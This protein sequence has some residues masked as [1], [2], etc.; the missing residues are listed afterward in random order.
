MVQLKYI[1][2]VYAM[3]SIGFLGFIVWSHHMYVTGLDV[4]KFVS[5][6]IV[7][8]LSSIVPYAGKLTCLGPLNNHDIYLTSYLTKRS[9]SICE[10]KAIFKGTILNNR[11]S[12]GNPLCST[13]D[14]L[15]PALI[16]DHLGPH[17]IP[18]DDNDFGH[19]LAGL[20]EGDGYFG[21]KSLEIV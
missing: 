10:T 2:M 15:V 8:Y 5:K 12:A 16:S 9:N 7:I 19:Y 21:H 4:D 11:R 18:K 13:R 20:I 14:L 6:D 1:G 3:L 17:L